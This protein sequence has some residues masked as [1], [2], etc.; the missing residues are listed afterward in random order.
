MINYIPIKRTNPELFTGNPSAWG[1]I[2]T[3]LVDIIERFK[4]NPK[5]ALEFGTEYGYSTSALANYFESV[6][7]VDVYVGD[8]QTGIKK[9]HYEY[10]KK[11]LSKWE[12]INLIKSDYRDF[13]KT[14]ND[15]YDLIH[16]DI[17]HTYDATF[18]CGDWALMHSD[19]VIF[20][21]T[22]SFPIIKQVCKDLSTKH[23]FEFY[24]YVP[25]HGLGILVKK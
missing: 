12:N 10:T 22:E 20:H 15:H 16:I 24:N 4:I 7:G 8:T 19:I 6:T 14:N 18:G 5:T 11:C 21:D 17:L 2:P 23:N 9:D 3:I 25:S 13:I 1:D